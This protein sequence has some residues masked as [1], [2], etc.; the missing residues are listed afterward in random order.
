MFLA[1]EKAKPYIC[2]V[3][4]RLSDQEASEVSKYDSI[5]AQRDVCERYIKLREEQGWTIIRMKYDDRNVSGGK[6][7]RP[8]LRRLIADA[9]Q[10]KFN[11]I[12]VKSV[13][14][15]TRS[16]K[17]FYELWDILRGA[18][19]ELASATQEFNTATST[20]RLHLDIVLR[21]A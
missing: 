16:L 19:I 1:H 13:D 12:V 20:G 5:E 6:L 11:M 21:F 7:D 2:A 9:K 15:F 14:R 17:H 8:A 18:G 3:Y 10:G 4:C